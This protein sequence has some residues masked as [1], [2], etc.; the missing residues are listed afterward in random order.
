MIIDA[1]CHLGHVLW[2]APAIYPDEVRARMAAAGVDKVCCYSFIDRIDNSYIYDATRE[3]GDLIPFACMDPTGPGAPDELEHWLKMGMR[4][5]KLHPYAHGYRLSSPVADQLF[6]LCGQYGVPVVCHLADESP[7]NTVWQAAERADRFPRVNLI[8]LHSGFLWSTE[9]MVSAA[10]TRPN[11]YLETSLI[12]TAMLRKAV[13]RIGPDKFVFGT[14][15]PW[16]DYEADLLKVR[17]AVPSARDQDAILGGTM[18]R[19][20]RL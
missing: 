1:Q 15:T 7:S 18:A 4:G 6:E 9:D 19:L 2:Q 8:A 14:D 13:G 17:R 10:A 12:S 5:M 20:L 16:N 11:L 3:G